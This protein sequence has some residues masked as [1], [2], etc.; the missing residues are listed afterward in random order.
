MTHPT[1]GDEAPAIE[2]A[3]LGQLVEQVDRVF[4]GKRDVVRLATAAA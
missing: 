4:H 3:R 2:L 1:V